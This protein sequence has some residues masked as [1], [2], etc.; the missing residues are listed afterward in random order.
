[1]NPGFMNNMSPEQIQ[2]NLNMMNPEMMKN[3]S[4]ML[5]GMSDSQLQMYLSQMGMPGM[6]PQMFRSMCQNMSNMSDSQ[7]NSMKSMAQSNINNM[8]M[9]NNTYNNNNNTNSN[10]KLKGTIVEQVTNIK[11][12]GNDLFKKEKFEEAIKKYYE[13]IEEIKTSMDRDKYKNELNDLE[14]ICRLNIASCKLKTKDYDGV[15]N[16]CS[17]VLE[18]NK[19]FKAY[20]RMGLALFHKQKY[21]K[22]FRYLDNANAIGN[23]NEK[24]LV[25]PH[26][27]E[28]RDKLDEIKMKEREERLRKEREKEKEMEKKKEES[29]K[30]KDINEKKGQNEENNKKE[31]NDGNNIK[32][33]IKNEIKDE[34][35]KDENIKNDESK[36]KK[37]EEK[38]ENKDNKLDNLRNVIEKEKEKNRKSK[39]KEDEE[40]D[41]KIED[42]KEPFYSNN[43]NNINTNINNNI[44][45][46]NNLNNTPKFSQEYINQARDQMKNMTDE[47]MNTMIW[48]MKNMDNQ[49]LKNLMAAQGMNLSD[50]QIEMMKNSLS[51]EL[52]RMVQNQN[53][54][55][56]PMNQNNNNS[57]NDITNNNINTNVNTNN[58]STQPPQMPNLGNMDFTQM[59]EFIKKNPQILKMVSPQLSQMMGGKDIDPELMMKSMENIMWIFSI[60]GRIK[61][62]MLSWRGICL[63]VF[64]IAIF[65]GIFKR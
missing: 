44:N 18:T 63:I 23:Q 42:T 46:N 51:P 62:F 65:Y 45:F 17:I 5:A 1:M 30:N 20:L 16:E 34:I 24:K 37:K 19:C 15:I 53:F 33:E 36:T 26:L 61:R 39:E 48:Q 7:F 4:S 9:N 11:T 38:T 3:A 47:Q 35:K 8:N 54:Q 31:E 60:P 10:D 64:I 55:N 6:N 2:A 13:A 12:E 58:N 52:L 27:K 49:T 29:N 14:R 25:E 43:N 41:I 59:M 22:A 57:N 50:Q 32:N 28:C 56:P 40:D 21:D